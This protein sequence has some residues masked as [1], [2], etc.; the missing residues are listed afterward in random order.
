MLLFGQNVLSVFLPAISKTIFIQMFFKKIMQVL[1]IS[2]ILRR[3]I[4][5]FQVNDI[6]PAIHKIRV[7]EGGTDKGFSLLQTI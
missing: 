4:S 3:F 1:S 2:F 5:Q 7:A 6:F